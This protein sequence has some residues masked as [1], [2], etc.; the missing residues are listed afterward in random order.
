MFMKTFKK[1]TEFAMTERSLLIRLLERLEGKRAFPYDDADGMRVGGP[2]GKRTI[3]G[4]LTIGIGWNLEVNP[5]PDHII[6]E[7]T[8]WM[9][10]RMYDELMKAVPW[11]RTQL[12][13]NR[14]TAL[15][16]MAYQM[17]VG[18]VLRFEDMWKALRDKDWNAAA[19]EA[20][21]SGW[22]RRFRSRARFIA[23]ILRTG[24]ILE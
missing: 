17:G 13:D 18:G 11:V 19:E 2:K 24:Q 12:D 7:M 6:Y 8:G 3:D 5:L 20:L 4:N 22:A 15:M 1:E 16:L 23:E 9:V 14:Q 21:D 10:A